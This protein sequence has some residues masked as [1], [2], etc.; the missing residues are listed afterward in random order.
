MIFIISQNLQ[1]A[2]CG[3]FM[4][5]FPAEHVRG[6]GYF[7]H[8]PKSWSKYVVLPKMPRRVINCSKSFLYF[9]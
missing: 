9:S 1:P 4:W 8:G 7:Y 5:T 2:V 3:K 6:S